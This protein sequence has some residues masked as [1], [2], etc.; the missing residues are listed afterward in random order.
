MTENLQKTEKPLQNRWLV[1][2]AA[3]VLELA[4]GAIYAWGIYVPNLVSEGWADWQTQLPYSISL[5]SFAVTTVFAGKLKWY[6]WRGRYWIRLR[7]TNLNR[8]S[9]VSR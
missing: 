2:I 5:A 1:V 7:F 3:V 6:Y 8:C 9:L 4:L